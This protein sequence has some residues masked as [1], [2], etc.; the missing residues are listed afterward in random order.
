MSIRAIIIAA[1]GIVSAIILILLVAGIF[2]SSSLRRDYAMID[3][4]GQTQYRIYR[5]AYIVEEMEINPEKRETLEKELNTEIEE[6]EK[7]LLG[8]KNG[9]P[10]LGLIKTADKRT[11][12]ALGENLKQWEN[13][14]KTLKGQAQLSSENMKYL[15]HEYLENNLLLFSRSMDGTASLLEETLASKVMRYK[16]GL[17]VLSAISF[18]TLGFIFTVLTRRII[19][20]LSSITKGIEEIKK[21]DFNRQIEVGYPDELGRVGAAYNEMVASLRETIERKRDLIENLPVAIIESTKDGNIKYLNKIAL[22]WSGYNKEEILGRR[23]TEFI[24]RENRGRIEEAL[25]TVLGGVPVRELQTPVALKGGVS[26]FEF[27]IAPIVEG[28]EVVG[29]RC[30]SK[31][32]EKT[33]K[34]LDEL[35]RAKKEAEE[36]SEKLRRTVKDLE[37]FALIAARREMKM[38]KIREGSKPGVREKGQEK[39]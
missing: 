1:L 5:F 3:L 28:K 22:A 23:L 15:E 2:F 21:G 31:D 35:E 34:M 20:P 37:E 32:I 16:E 29:L 25:K 12:D 9:E 11:A 36:T 33:K 4:A 30:V 26:R 19:G 8:L 6:F 27:N 7:I 38:Q 24:P 17:V 18:V 14:K 13:I 10:R 39:T